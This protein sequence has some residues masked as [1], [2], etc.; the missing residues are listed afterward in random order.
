MAHLAL[1]KPKEAINDL[2]E[3]IKDS[4]S[5][6]MNFH[7]ALAHEA[8]GDKNSASRALK[9]AQENY[10]LSYEEVPKIERASYQRLIGSLATAK[11]KEK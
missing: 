1:G 8:A 9:V 4:P 7:L 5:G 10:Q 11:S 3:A 6:I 2:R